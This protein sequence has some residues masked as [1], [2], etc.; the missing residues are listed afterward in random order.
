MNWL[1]AGRAGFGVAALAA[2]DTLGGRLAGVRLTTQTRWAVRILGARQLLEAAVCA[3]VPTRCMVQLEAVVDGIHAVT[4]GVAAAVARRPSTRRAAAV[5][6]VT[7]GVFLLADL[8]VANTM[9]VN[10]H[11][12]HNRVLQLRDRLAQWVCGLLRIP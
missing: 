2:P 4:M 10:G 3:P 6:V 12:E 5:N 1:A 9:E 7:A 8:Y 11:G